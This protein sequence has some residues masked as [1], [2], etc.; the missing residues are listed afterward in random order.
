MS[1]KHVLWCKE[2]S[3]DKVWGII[4]LEQV[5]AS[6]E[7]FH[8]FPNYKPSYNKFLTFWGRRGAKLQTKYWEGSNYDADEMARKKLKKGYGEIDQN[9]LDEVYPEFQND[10]EKTELW[11][12]LKL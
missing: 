7:K 11:A 3:H 2:D 9:F 5:P 12:K 10:L 8:P 4:C 6:H 1:K